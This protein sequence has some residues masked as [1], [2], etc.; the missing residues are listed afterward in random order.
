MILKLRAFLTQKLLDKNKSE[1]DIE[2]AQARGIGRPSV[3]RNNKQLKQDG[4]L[5]TLGKTR[6]GAGQ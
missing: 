4:K 3:Y 1:I 2:T 5:G 6:Q